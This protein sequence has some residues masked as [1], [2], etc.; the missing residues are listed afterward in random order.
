MTKIRE[1][2]SFEAAITRVIGQIGDEAAAAAVKRSAAHVRR[3]SDPDDAN[4]PNI[5]QALALDSAFVEAGAGD[6]PLLSAYL[7]MLKERVGDVP[8]DEMLSTATLRLNGAAGAFAEK[9]SQITRP[10]SDGGE[11][12]TP[13]EAAE[14]IPALERVD[15][16]TD[17]LFS[18][19]R[20]KRRAPEK[21]E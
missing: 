4:L 18:L 19:L 8:T 5:D 10:D 21:P 2:R 14:C 20:R 12:I 3:W 11:T 7:A 1:P 16:A 17:T 9:I 13:R 6:P 15:I